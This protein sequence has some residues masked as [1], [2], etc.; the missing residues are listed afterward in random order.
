[1]L[2]F[3]QIHKKNRNWANERS[4]VVVEPNQYTTECSVRAPWTQGAEHKGR[5]QGKHRFEI[6]IVHAPS[7]R[8]R[9]SGSGLGANC[10]IAVQRVC[11]CRYRSLSALV[12]YTGLKLLKL[13]NT[14]CTQWPGNDCRKNGG[15]REPGSQGAKKRARGHVDAE[16]K[17]SNNPQKE[18]ANAG[19]GSTT[20]SEH[21]LESAS[22]SDRAA[23]KKNRAG[24]T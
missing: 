12:I 7:E 21:P 10:G 17:D 22:R 16:M 24:D 9:Q 18:Q 15:A 11:K 1:M 6:Y 14:I 20:G 2:T 8:K 3:T 13:V 4:Y 5:A 19:W 23:E